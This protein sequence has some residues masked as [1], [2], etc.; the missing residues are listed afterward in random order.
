LGPPESRHDAGVSKDVEDKLGSFARDRGGIFTRGDAMAFG[1]PAATISSRVSSGL[2]V[3][4]L[5]GLRAATTPPT[6]NGRYWAAL[7]RGG[8]HAALS[9][10]SAAE[11]WGLTAPSSEVVWL[12]VPRSRRIRP[13]PGLR[14]VRTQHLPALA[15]RS[16]RELPVLTPARTIVDLALIWNARQLTAAALTGIQRGLCGLSELKAWHRV[17]STRPGA[18]LMR[19]VLEELDPAFESILAAEFG[20]L[21]ESAGLGLVP[22]Y[23]VDLPD[24]FVVCD[25]ADPAARVDFEV[26]GLA[27]HSDRDQ[28]ARDKAR[29]RRLARA[30]WL[31]VRYDTD[32]IRRAPR[33]TIEDARQQQVVR[34][35]QFLRNEL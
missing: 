7:A 30:G 21:A 11:V 25:F 14:V 31:T 13:G 19:R 12:T 15:V 33:A 8:P 1:L 17:F 35:A 2:W 29:D 34:R 4:E 9:H 23:R 24:G 20:A 27:Y 5:G 26:D 16:H 28:V 32:N 6:P 3:P 22:G 10:L 18:G